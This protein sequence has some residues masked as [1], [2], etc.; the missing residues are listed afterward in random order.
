MYKPLCKRI[1][2]E[3]L[4]VLQESLICEKIVYKIPCFDKKA[5]V[6][7]ISNYKPSRHPILTFLKACSRL[8]T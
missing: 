5:I 1:L 7:K 3:D 4:A 6:L 8:S 2:K